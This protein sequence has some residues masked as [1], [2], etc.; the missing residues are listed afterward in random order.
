MLESSIVTFIAIS[1][2]S[3]LK[4]SDIYYSLKGNSYEIAG[5]ELIVL[6]IPIILEILF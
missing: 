4:E 1:Q 3:S 6:C 5:S 2:D